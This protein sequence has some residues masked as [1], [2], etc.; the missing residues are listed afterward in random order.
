MK[1]LTFSVLICGLLA[2]GCSTSPESRDGGSATD[3][4]DADYHILLAEIALQR[5]QYGVAAN[6]YYRAARLSDDAELAERAARVA[7]SYGTYEQALGTAN[8]WAELAP[9]AVDA[10]RYLVLLYLQTGRDKDAV[11]HLE[12]LYADTAAENE[13]GYGALLP[14]LTEAR[15]TDAAYAATVRLTKRAKDDPTAHYAHGFMALQASDIETARVE[16]KAAS[17]ARPEWNEPRVLLARATLAGGDTEGA[18]RLLSDQPGFRDDISLRLEYAILQL[19]ADRPEEA[20]LQLELLLEAHPRLP[21]ALRTLGFLEYQQGNYELAERYFIELMATRRYVSDAL[22]YLGGMSENEGDL[23]S[24]AGFYARVTSGGNTVAARVR[25]SLILYRLGRSEEALRQLEH[26]EEA[27]PTA[28]VEL[29]SARGDLLSRLERY[30]EALTL[31][32]RRLERYPDDE[33]LLYARAFLYERMDRVD[34]AIAELEGLLERDPD[35]PVA[36]NALGY[37]LADRTTRYE[38]ARRYIGRALELSPYSPAI[39]DSMGWVEYRM[40]NYPESIEYLRR[41]WAL[42]R[43]PEIAAHLGEVLWV[44]GDEEGARDIWFESLQE[45]PESDALREVFERFQPE[46]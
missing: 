7:F 8:R 5:Q 40:G 42:D 27:D 25:L 31:Y 24:A 12:K 16:A 43:D 17:D 29:A 23:D 19:S 13:M 9:D 15:D 18:L 1:N 36:L 10:R 44:N 30:D 38:E 2:A 45:N 33:T 11:E 34:D 6:E 26:F 3:A 28:A 41:A 21:G 46:P 22:F 14:L 20:R 39:V 37:T 35:D 32:E 4:T